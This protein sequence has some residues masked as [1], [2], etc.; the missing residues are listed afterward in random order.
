MPKCVCGRGFAPDLTEGADVAPTH[1]LVG[2]GGDTLSPHGSSYL[3]RLQF[4]YVVESKKSL[5]YSLL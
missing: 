4:A 3:T 2:W 5:N 1:S